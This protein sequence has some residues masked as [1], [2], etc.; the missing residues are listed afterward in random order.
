MLCQL[1]NTFGKREGLKS[2]LRW[3]DLEQTTSEERLVQDHGVRHER[4]LGEL[5]VGESIDR[6]PEQA[7][8]WYLSNSYGSKSNWT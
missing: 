3:T 8:T 6:R 5:D 7:Y 1:W 2:I 4:G